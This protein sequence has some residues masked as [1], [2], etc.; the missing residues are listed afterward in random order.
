VVAV[1]Y[2]TRYRRVPHGPA[3]FAVFHAECSSLLERATELDAAQ[4]RL[5]VELADVRTRLAEMRVVM[6]PRVE[7]KDIVQGFR[8]THRGGPPPI[9]PVVPGAQPLR[10]KHL[11]SATLAIL[12]LNDTPM[13]L[14]EL[15]RELHL[16]GY[17][18]ASRPTRRLRN[19]PAEPGD[20]PPPG[21]D[22]AT[23]RARPRPST[24]RRRWDSS[25]RARRRPR[26]LPSS[27]GRCPSIPRRSRP[28]GPS[29]SRGAQ[30]PPRCS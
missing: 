19:R 9:P 26:A 17:A 23:T 16:N 13:T 8:V 18:I 22:R 6:W 11:R 4:R 1:R 14:V 7:P 24:R 5:V 21:E 28:R 10:G 2:P 29:S 3:E 30:S 20:T 12:A 25:R 27:L 15:H